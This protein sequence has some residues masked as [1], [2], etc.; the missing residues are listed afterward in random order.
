MCISCAASGTENLYIFS[1]AA[2]ASI[3][4]REERDDSGLPDPLGYS[5]FIEHIHISGERVNFRGHVANLYCVWFA[6]TT[7]F[8][9][10]HCNVLTRVILRLPNGPQPVALP[11]SFPRS[12]APKFA[13]CFLRSDSCER[14]AGQHTTSR[15]NF[16]AAISHH[17]KK[18]RYLVHGRR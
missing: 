1:L 4:R 11:D 3:E 13:A 7:L 17:S 16:K 12:L 14:N 10:P 8:Q 5:L 15:L 18:V 6:G 2:H 9:T